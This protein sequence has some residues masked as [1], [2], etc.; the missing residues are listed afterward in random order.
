MK[1][2]NSTEAKEMELVGGGLSPEKL[3]RIFGARCV[4]SNGSADYKQS[5]ACQCSYGPEN[6]WANYNIAHPQ[7]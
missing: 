2:N 1:E 7:E 6:G 4:C 5:G 3:K